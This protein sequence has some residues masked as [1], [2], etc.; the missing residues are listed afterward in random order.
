MPKPY[1]PQV[2]LHRVASIINLRET[3]AIVNHFQYD[4]LTGL[5]SKEFF[6]Q[7]VRDRLREDPEGAYSIVCSNVENFKLYN[8]TFGVAAGDRLLR[9]I[10]DIMRQMLGGRSVCGRFS[11]DRFMCLQEWDQEKRDRN[12][13][14]PDQKGLANG[15][16]VV[17][18]WGIYEITD[19]TVPVEQ[20]CDRALLAADSIKGQYNRYF[21]VYD[22]ALRSKLLREQAITE[23]METALREGQF[24]VYLQPKYSLNDDCLAGAEA[25]VRWIHPEWGFLSPGEFIPLFEK[26][27]FI[28]RLDRYV[29][30]QVCVQLK[31]WQEKGY[32]PLPVS[33][34]VSRA[35]IY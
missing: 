33:V 29:W 3:A 35:D 31:S 16:S 8:D 1:R 26:N 27:G 24:Q 20:M 23:A 25:L 17:M 5:Y 19:R 14:D 4:R 22:D 9:E 18:R 2:I 28:T 11:G 21:A 10:A 32:P 15:P 6:Y 34:N 13:F 30:E 12:A 7:K